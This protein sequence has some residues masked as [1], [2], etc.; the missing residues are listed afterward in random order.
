MIIRFEVAD[1]KGKAFKD[2]CKRTGVS[3]S[4]FIRSSIDDFVFDGVEKKVESTVSGYS[5]AA[6]II[7]Y[8]KRDDETDEEWKERIGLIKKENE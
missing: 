1:S 4:Q 3:M 2:K 6:D 7:T 5:A 8:N